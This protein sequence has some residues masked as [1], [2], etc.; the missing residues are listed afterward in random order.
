V[1]DQGSGIAA[2][3]LDNI[4]EPFFTTKESGTGLGLALVHQM[5][6]E[7]GGTII[8]ESRVGEGTTFRVTLPPAPSTLRQSA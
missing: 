5:V 1:C 3:E 7:H 6:V 4:F 2:E 8:V